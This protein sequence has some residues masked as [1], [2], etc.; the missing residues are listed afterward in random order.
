M[1]MFVS[2]LT[3]LFSLKDN[4]EEIISVIYFESVNLDDGDRT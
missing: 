3:E 1:V 2:R 4:N